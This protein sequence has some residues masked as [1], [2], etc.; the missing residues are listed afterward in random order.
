[1]NQRNTLLALATA[2]VF[3]SV[4]TG[5]RERD[6]V[7]D[8]YNGHVAPAAEGVADDPV[9]RTPADPALM[10]HGDTGM[11]DPQ[12]DAM[13]VNTA[14]EDRN[15]SVGED[16]ATFLSGALASGEAEVAISRHVQNNATSQDVRA[17]AKRIAND[18]E[19]LNRKLRDAGAVA[20]PAG[21]AKS[22]GAADPADT[23]KAAATQDA[24]AHSGTDRAADAHPMNVEIRAKRGVE[25]ERA[26]L[27]HILEGHRK[28]I[29][30][31]EAAAANVEFA[32]GTRRLAEQALPTIREHLDAVEA[33]LERTR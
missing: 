20:D 1:M 7:E 32:A 30:R 14:A 25:M 21:A 12:N 6:A 10:P 3:V 2:W 9:A 4:S 24:T 23:T 27:T 16:Q 11:D 22:S 31:Y 17:L 18:H 28:S 5:C 8:G 26:Y 33:A 15:R 19:A 13:P 29:A